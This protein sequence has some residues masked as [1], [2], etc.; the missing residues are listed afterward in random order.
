MLD[1]MVFGIGAAG[2]K[3]A[4]E[5]IEQRVIDESNV[6]LI[7][8]TTK[9][10]PEKYK[11]DASRVIK[12]SSMLGGCGKEPTKGQKAMYQAIKNKDINFGT[13][14]NPDTKAVVLVTSVE[15]GT[16]CG[17]TP[18]VAKY[19][20]ALNIPVHVFAFVGFQDETRGVGNTLMFFKELPDNVILHTID[21]N[22]FLDFTKNFQKAEHAANEEFVNQLEVLIGSGMVPSEQNIDDTDHYKLCTTPGYMDIRHVELN[23]AKNMD[24]VNQAIIDSFEN[25]SCLEYNNSG[26]KRIAIIVNASSKTQEILDHR[27]D[28]IKRYTGEA[29]ETFHHIQNDG[30]NDEYIDIIICG[31]PY[32]EDKIKD[33]N[34]KYGILKDKIANAEVKA[35]SD[36]FDDIDLDLDNEE[37]S[38]HKMRNPDDILASFSLDD[39]PAPKQH[40]HNNNKSAKKVTNTINNY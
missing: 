39:E 20:N 35:L 37:T 33:I 21:N 19:F 27:F 40:N 6:K 3:A 18:V 16:G 23:G 11:N 17:A 28:V 36:I 13:I 15:G 12:F 9:D 7:N 38:I 24:L 30:H 8:T 34:K 10:I 25:M 32:P 26:C 31:L 29:F 1:L 22:K 4:I 14:V 5:A 2:N